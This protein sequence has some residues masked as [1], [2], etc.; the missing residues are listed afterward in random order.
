MVYL[1][2]VIQDMLALIAA[3]FQ[4]S[5]NQSHSVWI[6]FDIDLS[7]TLLRRIVIVQFIYCIS[8]VYVCVWQMKGHYIPVCHKTSVSTLA[9]QLLVTFRNKTSNLLQMSLVNVNPVSIWNRG[10][11]FWRKVHM[12][13]S[14]KQLQHNSFYNRIIHITQY[15]TTILFHKEYWMHK[16]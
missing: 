6:A 10:A 7:W 16:Y 2:T 8:E 13:N 5:N 1:F 4:D 14:C 11:K 15:E 3:S 12:Q 9:L